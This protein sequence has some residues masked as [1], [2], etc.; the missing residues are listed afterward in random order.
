MPHPHIP[1]PPKTGTVSCVGYF[2]DASDTVGLLNFV[3]DGALRTDYTAHV[4]TKALAGIKLEAGMNPVELARKEPGKATLGLRRHAQRLLELCLS[5][6]VDGFQ[7]YVVSLLREILAK[8]PRIL[9]SSQPTLSLEYAFAFGSIEELVTDVVE[10]KVGDLSYQG[11]EKLKAWCAEREIILAVEP[12][13]AALLADFIATRNV[14]AHNRGLVDRKYLR[15]VPTSTLPIGSQRTLHSDD[16]FEAF[17]LLNRVV[18]ASDDAASV[19][20]GLTRSQLSVGSD[21]PSPTS[22]PETP[23]S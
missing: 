6:L 9:K 10:T 7:S 1:P 20:F 19:K 22:P 14:I 12:E 21:A 8:D 13:D 2:A 18:A 23:S 4:A 11:F 15:A 5:R 17:A 16:V 3:I